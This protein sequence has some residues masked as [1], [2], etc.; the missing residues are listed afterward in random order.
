MP[1]AFLLLII[2]S[3]ATS[4][5]RSTAIATDASA[6]QAVPYATGKRADT[7]NLADLERGV[8]AAGQSTQAMR[9]LLGS[10][11]SVSP[12]AGGGGIDWFI[13]PQIPEKLVGFGYNSDGVWTGQIHRANNAPTQPYPGGQ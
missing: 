7:Q 5:Q 11:H 2:A 8:Y 10:P 3:L 1:I 6:D 13:D 12:G 4:C 9:G